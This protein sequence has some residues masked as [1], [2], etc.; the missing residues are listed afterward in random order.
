MHVQYAMWKQAKKKKKTA[1][2]LI[3]PSRVEQALGK[4]PLTDALCL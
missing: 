1:V 3:L 4:L 2:L